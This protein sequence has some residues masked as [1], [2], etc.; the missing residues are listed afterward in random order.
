MRLS[1]YDILEGGYLPGNFNLDIR[2][3]P[4]FGVSGELLINPL[5]NLS[6]R[7]ELAQLRFYTRHQLG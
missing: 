7:L 3:E 6:L 4:Y 1:H 2:W 5:K